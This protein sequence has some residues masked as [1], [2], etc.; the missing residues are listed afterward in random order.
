LDLQLFTG[1]VLVSA[2]IISLLAIVSKLVG[3]GLPLMREGWRSVLRV[4]FGIMPRG[5]VALIIA[6]VGLQSKIMTQSGYAIVVFMI[7]VTAILAPPF[8]RI[9]FS[10]KT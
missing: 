9:L 3:C 1:D 7:A 6:L 8:L 10:D 5:E 4:G 2:I